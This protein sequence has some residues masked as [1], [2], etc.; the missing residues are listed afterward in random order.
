MSA[1]DI[2]NGSLLSPIQDRETLPKLREDRRGEPRRASLMNSQ[3]LAKSVVSK[4]H[5]PKV[6]TVKSRVAEEIPT[7]Q[8]LYPPVNSKW[9]RIVP[10]STEPPEP[11]ILVC[12]VLCKNCRSLVPVVGSLSILEQI[13][14]VEDNELPTSSHGQREPLKNDIKQVSGNG[15]VKCNHCRERTV[16]NFL[17]DSSDFMSKFS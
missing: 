15:V 16:S 5:V 17:L 8:S 2:D 9:K 14:Q 10:V 4:F 12:A 11:I 6:P 1:R 13:P 7:S 3:Q